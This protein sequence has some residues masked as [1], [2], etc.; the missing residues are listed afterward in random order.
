MS[1][2]FT[3]CKKK[4]GVQYLWNTL[5]ATKF[6]YN[7][8]VICFRRQTACTFQDGQNIVCTFGSIP[9]LLKEKRWH[10]NSDKD[11]SILCTGSSHVL[12][13]VC[14][15][16]EMWNLTEKSGQSHFQ[17]E[18]KFLFTSHFTRCFLNSMLKMDKE[19]LEIGDK[20]YDLKLQKFVIPRCRTPHGWTC[21]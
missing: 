21:S 5:C 15:T 2:S 17:V 13:L 12:W 4:M 19:F 1:W 8:S 11:V 20:K 7:G 9:A 14:S 18:F 16:K 10:F 6:S 3:S